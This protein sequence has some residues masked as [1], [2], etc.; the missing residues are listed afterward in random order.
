MALPVIGEALQIHGRI[1]ESAVLVYRVSDRRSV[2]AVRE[3]GITV[4]HPAVDRSVIVQSNGRL[5]SRI[6]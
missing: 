1:W 3:I 2:S 4:R 5:I 6:L